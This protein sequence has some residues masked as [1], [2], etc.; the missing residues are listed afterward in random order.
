MALQE[1]LSMVSRSCRVP[2][3]LLARIIGQIVLMSVAL[4]PVTQ[5]MTRG[6][7][8]KLNNRV[9][10]CQWLSIAPDAKPELGY[11]VS[12][13]ELFNGQDI[14]AKISAVR[15][16]YSDANETGYGVMQSSM[17]AK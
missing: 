4:G 7:Y 15:L 3:K 2:T 6:L 12:C 8:A 1:C 17:V 16:V 10:W 11:W 14:W 13:M 5:L 9:V